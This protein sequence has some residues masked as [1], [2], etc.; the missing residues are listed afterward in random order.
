MSVSLKKED[1]RR[2]RSRPPSGEKYE[3]QI[4]DSRSP[5]EAFG[6]T[7]RS[8]RG[9]D[10]ARRSTCHRAEQA[11][12][13]LHRAATRGE[14]TRHLNRAMQHSYRAP[15]RGP[16]A[17]RAR[18]SPP[19]HRLRVAQHQRRVATLRSGATLQSAGAASP[20]ADPTARPTRASSHDADAGQHS[21]GAPP[22]RAGA[23]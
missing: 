9:A 4:C 7:L 22:H 1:P 10:L 13:D 17:T 12:R 23:A 2:I 8:R 3:Q 19:S 15:A 5:G 6:V 11:S 21:A 16:G 20:H 18:T 14:A